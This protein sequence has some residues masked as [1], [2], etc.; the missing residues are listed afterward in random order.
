ASLLPTIRSRVAVVTAEDTS[1]FDP[2]PNELEA[3]ITVLIGESSLGA[4][5]ACIA[6]L[7]A[8]KR[9]Q[10]CFALLQQ[11]LYSEKRYDDLAWW[12][13]YDRYVQGAP[14][15]R[16]IFEAYSIWRVA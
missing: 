3:E 15:A 14:N 7:Y 9:L 6:Q 2:T 16:L 10:D 12:G 4:Q 13:R 8:S 5:F 11:A 1:T